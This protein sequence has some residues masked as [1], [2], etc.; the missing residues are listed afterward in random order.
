MLCA[1]ADDACDK[2][3]ALG[4]K[5]LATFASASD[6]AKEVVLTDKLDQKQSCTYVV[7]ATCDAPYMQVVEDPAAASY[8]TTAADLDFSVMEYRAFTD[9][10]NFKYTPGTYATLAAATTVS[11]ALTGIKN[12]MTDAQFKLLP[13]F[14]LTANLKAAK[15]AKNKQGLWIADNALATFYQTKG[16]AGDADVDPFF[17][18]KAL[19]AKRD[20]NAAY[21]TAKSAYDT[22]KSDYDTKL[23]AAE[24]VTDAQKK[25]IFK[26]WFPTKEDTDAVKAVPTRPSKPSQPAATMLP[27]GVKP[28]STASNTVYGMSALENVKGVANK[29]FGAWASWSNLEVAGAT[30]GDKPLTAGKSWGTTGYGA[31]NE[32]EPTAAG[33]NTAIGVTFTTKDFA[34]TPACIKHY[35]VTQVGVIAYGKQLAATKELKLKLGVNKWKYTM[36]AVTQ[37]AA[38]TDPA[39]PKAAAQMLTL[40]AAVIATTMTL[41]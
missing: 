8:P 36:D 10:T 33:G 17:I 15:G 29:G 12:K 16:K 37:P 39:T 5:K 4:S 30:A 40:G 13:D 3:S 7:E 25:D 2:S 9:T 35:M 38:A 18:L 14:G 19:A 6:A 41:F 26:A 22:K 20:E 1:Q 21:E 24:K 34:A 28:E 32:A 11:S 31:S 27:Q 23:A